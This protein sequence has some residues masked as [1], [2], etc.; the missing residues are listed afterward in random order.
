MIHDDETPISGENTP[1]ISIDEDF[2]SDETSDENPT[3]TNEVISDFN[4]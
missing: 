2:G 1:V 3:E 4:L